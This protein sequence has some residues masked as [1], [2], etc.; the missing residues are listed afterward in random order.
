MTTDDEEDFV[1]AEHSFFRSVCGRGTT[2]SFVTATVEF[3][4]LFDPAA[5]P[6]SAVSTPRLVSGLPL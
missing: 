1:A 4:P 6:S 2:Y 5:T 3:C